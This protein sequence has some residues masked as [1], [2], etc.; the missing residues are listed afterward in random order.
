MATLHGQPTLDDVI[1]ALSLPAAYA[2]DVD[3]VEVI[4]TH[5]SCVFLAGEHVY[6]LKKPLDL[7]F[8]DYSTPARRRAMCRA[9]VRL[10][11]PRAPGVYLGVVPIT[12]DY[13]G[14]R[15]AG[16]G[17]VID[18]V[19]HMR[20]LPDERNLEALIRSGAA[21]PAVM[22]DLGRRLAEFHRNADRSHEIAPWGRFDVV[23]GNCR[24]NFA[25]IRANT[26]G[27]LGVTVTPT[28]LNRLEHLTETTL[29]ARREL[30]DARA[31]AHIPC[32]THGDLRLEH[33]Y[34]LESGELLAIDCIEFNDRFRY[35][36][37]IADL[38]FLVMDLERLNR[39]DLA[40]PLEEAYFAAAND[41]EGL[42]LLPF[43][44]AYRATVRGKVGGFTVASPEVPEAQRE[45]AR[46]EA[47]ARF[48]HAFGAL[49]TPGER[50]CLLLTSGLP[51]TGKSTLAQGL[52][53]SAGAVWIRADAVR[54]E[55]AGIDPLTSA[56]AQFEA[57]IYTREWSD[58]TYAACLERAERVLLEGGRVVVDATFSDPARRQPF[59]ALCR[60]LHV[61]CHQLRCDASDYTI[62][63]RLASNDPNPSDATV[64]IYERMRE[65]WT[66]PDLAE[67]PTTRVDTDRRPDDVLRCALA[68][69]RRVGLES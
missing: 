67:W 4:Q 17:R 6:K 14:I 19:V 59:R 10:N 30:I 41:A 45:L 36:D 8:L 64:E 47:Q 68:A 53:R 40:E 57:G 21:T 28:L 25:Q 42:A 33:V 24:E 20:R 32:D 46:E 55:L 61:P 1:A 50:P 29:R 44:V 49:A 31:A 66:D 52:V 34:L 7:G 11:E 60:R 56:K 37:P 63:K 9:E 48:L 35:S 13:D 27:G 18:H 12:V 65:R 26:L 54:K 22:D 15:V 2:H 39:P 23:A 5:I 69:L 51:A 58:R 16:N 38:A 43:Y 3:A 62:R